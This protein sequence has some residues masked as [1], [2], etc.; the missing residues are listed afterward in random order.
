MAIVDKFNILS[1]IVE[2]PLGKEKSYET[3]HYVCRLGSG[4]SD[5]AGPRAGL[6]SWFDMWGFVDE[7]WDVA[8]KGSF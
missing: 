1:A 2:L 7:R 3:Y 4:D 5:R 8:V 6:L